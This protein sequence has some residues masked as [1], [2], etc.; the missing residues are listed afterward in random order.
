MNLSLVSK[1][2]IGFIE[3]NFHLIILLLRGHRPPARDCVPQRKLDV[4]KPLTAQGRRPL[5][6]L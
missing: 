2:D 5:A 4:T 6:F 1:E 3:L